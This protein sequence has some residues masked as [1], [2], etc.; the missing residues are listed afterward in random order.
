MLKLLVLLI[1]V[2]ISA[3]DIKSHRIPNQYTLILSVLLLL[4][5]IAGDTRGVLMAILI[6]LAVGYFGKVGAGD[7]KLILALLFTSGSLLLNERYLYGAVLIS[8]LVLFSSALFARMKSLDIPK[9]I[10]LAPSILLPFLF[11]YLAI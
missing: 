8:L 7:I 6:V 4:D 2:R 5:Q 3:I 11:S 1:S 9:S 10:P